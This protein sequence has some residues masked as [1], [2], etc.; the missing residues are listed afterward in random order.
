MVESPCI[1]VCEYDENL[2]MCIGCFR[3]LDEISSWRSMTDEEKLK[4]I[5]RIE[6][7]KG[8]EDEKQ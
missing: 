5:E 8:L 4:V 1:S 6:Q 2:D 3:T 7:E